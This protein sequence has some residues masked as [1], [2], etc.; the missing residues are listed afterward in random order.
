M[1]EIYEDLHGKVTFM[2]IAPPSRE[3]VYGYGEIRTE[4]EN[5]TGN[6]NGMFADY[7]WVPLRYLNRSF[8]RD[9]LTCFYRQADVGLVTPLRDGMNLV[10]KEYIASQDP[11]DPGVLVLSQF[12]GAAAEMTEALIVNPHDPDEVANALYRA[13]QMPLVERRKRWKALMDQLVSHDIHYWR[14][15]F[16]AA[17][18]ETEREYA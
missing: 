6:I 14:R 10:A 13:L 8:S 2:Q 16:L 11:E 3:D 18:A 5:L 7:D 15:S 9:M 12:A 17:L 4:L 1:L